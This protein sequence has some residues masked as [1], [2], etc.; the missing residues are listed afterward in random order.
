M[1]YLGVAGLFS[2][3]A[4]LMYNATQDSFATPNIW[5]NLGILAGLTIYTV[6][7]K[8]KFSASNI[9]TGV[10]SLSTEEIK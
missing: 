10:A 2:W 5:I 6:E 9:P 4:I 8:N 3:L 1:R 7:L